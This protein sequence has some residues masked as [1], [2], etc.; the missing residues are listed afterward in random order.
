MAYQFNSFKEKLAGVSEWLAKELSAVTTG[1]ASIALLDGIRAES[2]GSMMP[3]N[4]LANMSVEDARTIRIVPWAADTLSSIDRALRE[5]NL[6]FSVSGDDKGIRVVFPELTG[7][8][9]E[10]Y[11]KVV[12][13][14]LEEARISVRA[15]REE[16]WTDIQ[17]QEKDGGMSEDDKFKAKENMEAM[18]KD[19]NEKLEA[20]AKKKEEDIR[21]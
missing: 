19:A 10:K 14:K 21:G 3:I 13:K 8:T 20:T 18:V 9:R 11:A 12:G 16:V 1:R 7:E 6:G 15:L 2:Y 4:Q 17:K 5:A